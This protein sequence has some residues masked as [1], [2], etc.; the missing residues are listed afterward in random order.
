MSRVT[1]NRRLLAQ[2]A[3]RGFKAGSCVCHRTYDPRITSAIITAIHVYHPGD[4]RGDD[5]PVTED[6]RCDVLPHVKKPMIWVE[7]TNDRAAPLADLVLSR[8][9]SEVRRRAVTEIN[10][11]I[12]GRQKDVKEANAGIRELGSAPE[13]SEQLLGRLLS[14]ANLTSSL[15][16]RPHLV[17]VPL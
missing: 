3:A 8:K 16:I 14:V 5:L 17:I 10:Q 7:L 12:K 13:S 2:A 15:D 4:Y 9:A 6:M 11:L 1:I